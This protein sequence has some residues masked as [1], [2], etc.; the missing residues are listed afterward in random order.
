V[1]WTALSLALGVERRGELIRGLPCITR[2]NQ[3]FC[4]KIKLNILLTKIKRLIRRMHGE[5]ISLSV[6]ADNSSK[7][8]GDDNP[9]VN[10]IRSKRQT[11]GPGPLPKSERRSKENYKTMQ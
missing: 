10:L 4:R 7:E 5:F 6:I 11:G 3:L 2:F 8:A 9:Y 1:L